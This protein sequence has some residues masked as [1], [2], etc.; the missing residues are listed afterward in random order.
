MVP[1]LRKCN[2]SEIA[3]KRPSQSL[4]NLAHIFCSQHLT[5]GHISAQFEL[6][7]G[8]KSIASDCTA[9]MLTQFPN[10]FSCVSNVSQVRKQIVSQQNWQKSHIGTRIGVKITGVFRSILPI[11]RET[12]LDSGRLAYI[13]PFSFSSNS[14]YSF[15]SIQVGS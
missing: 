7:T 12:V 1:G 9:G 8:D 3:D 5:R 15:Y 14:N 4:S 6:M 2:Q 10:S 13:K 11:I